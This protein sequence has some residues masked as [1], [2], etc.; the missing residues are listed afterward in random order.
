[1][2]R[3]GRY[4]ALA[5]LGTGGMATVYVGRA[6]GE[7]DFS[8]LVALK[9]AHEHVR[10]D[11]DLVDGLKREAGLAVRIHHPNVVG[12]LDVQEDPKDFVLV[13]EYVE[14]CALSELMQRI[15][16]AQYPREMLCILF[17]VAAGLDAAHHTTDETGA[18]LGLVH[19][20]VS[21]CNVLIGRDGVARIADF[22]VAKTVDRP[23][24]EKTTTGVLKGKL[25]YMAPEYIERHQLDARGDLFS[26][27]VVAWEMLTGDRLFK[28]HT[29]LETLKRVAAHKVPPPSAYGPHLALFD[30]SIMRAL[31]RDPDHRFPNV[32][33]FA[34]D[35]EARARAAGLVGSHMEVAALVERTFGQELAQRRQR[36][37]IQGPVSAE[38]APY[39]VPDTPS[40]TQSAQAMTQSDLA[41]VARSKLRVAI[42][43][44]LLLALGSVTT[45]ALLARRSAV[46]TVAA[47]PPAAMAL[48]SAASPPAPTA[49]AIATELPAAAAT[50]QASPEPASLGAVPSAETPAPA[51]SA[52]SSARE[53]A[54][55]PVASAAPLAPKPAAR[56][57]P[58][59]PSH[60]AG[61]QPASHIIPAKPPPNPYGP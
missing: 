33:A 27:A 17:D 53:P 32:G 31:A 16:T 28:G 4:E 25:A 36:C 21:P 12:V 46:Q 29:E 20:D 24:S 3:F 23:G 49:S 14:G 22:G 39:I 1:M 55:V 13:L 56:P 45:G 30:A 5:R 7:P 52:S 15:D 48:P 34:Y 18:P 19:R 44:S 58:R 57:S 43:L 51:S 59:P 9:R 38:G 50:V 26:L 61:S 10:L 40:S 6:L 37:G 60:P 2:R 8:R 42:P 35:L 54:A 11:P 47:Q 41:I